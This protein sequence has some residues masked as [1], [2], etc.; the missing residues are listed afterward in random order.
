MAM[1]ES[2]GIFTKYRSGAL[3]L[4]SKISLSILLVITI[5]FGTIIWFL[6]S[7]SANKA[8]EDAELL[9]VTTVT[10]IGSEVKML[11]DENIQ[12][13]QGINSLIQKM[14]RTAP[15]ARDIIS[16]TMEA[17][18]ATTPDMASA[19]IAFEPNAFDNRDADF[20]GKDGYNKTGRFIVCYINDNGVIKRTNDVNAD[21]ISKGDY[22]QVPLKTGKD[23][24]GAPYT[25]TYSSGRTTLISEASIPIIID[26]RVI[27]VVGADFDYTNIQKFGQDIHAISKGTTFSIISDSGV[28]IYSPNKDFIGKN[29]GDIIKGRPYENDVMSAI[30]DGKLFQDVNIAVMTGEKALRIFSPVATAID[31]SHLCINAVVPETDI[32]E[33]VGAMTRST[34]FV[35]LIGLAVVAV[36]VIFISSTIVR[37]IMLMVGIMRQAATLDLTTA[38][39]L[40]ALRRHKDE[41]GDMANAYSNFKESITDMLRALNTQARDFASTAQTLAAISEESVASM[42][43]V[44]ASVDEVARLSNDNVEALAQTNRGVDEVSHASAATAESAENGAGIAG[45]T[46]ELTRQ[47][48]SEVDSVVLSIRTAGER[49]LDSGQ[50]ILKVN[51]SVGAIASF[52]ST[53]TGIADQTNLL[54]LNA[55]IEAARAGEAGRGFAV[56]AEE[57]RKL[58]EESGRAAQEV[59]KLISVLQSDS[60][61]ASS[62]IEEMGKLLAEIAEKAGHAQEDL[63]KSL[64]EV[65]MLS[66]HMQTIASAAQEQAASSSEMASSVNMVSEST[67][68]IGTALGHIQSATAETAAASESVANEAQ[69]VTAGV[70]KLEELLSQFKYDDEPSSTD[71]SRLSPKGK[72]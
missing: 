29:M 48:F 43:E 54:A 20:A 70:T 4:R 16:L 71:A 19:W 37:P 13:M 28:I 15:N 18:L 64:R 31:G 1:S 67:D 53:I 61:S 32:L 14:D 52:V 10:E 51:D 12:A 3:R 33:D 36:V 24:L 56:V 34:I 60:G 8:R 45:R 66:G 39:S 40:L 57:V 41:I 65:D 2:S 5:I 6:A 7:S 62:V 63:N 58:A 35:A 25:F 50:S 22:Y 23:V 55:A 68:E 21:T 11:I 27:G 30:R 49:S 47:A 59:Q 46:A 72:K 42:E 17:S 38:N 9:A 44:K 69:E 26:G